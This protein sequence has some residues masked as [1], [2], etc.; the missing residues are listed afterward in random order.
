MCITVYQKNNSY[1]H[2]EQYYLNTLSNVFYL[3]TGSRTRGWNAG[4]VSYLCECCRIITCSCCMKL[5]SVSHDFHYSNQHTL[6]LSAIFCSSL[7]F[8]LIHL[9]KKNPFI[10]QVLN[11][12]LQCKHIV[13]SLLKLAYN[14]Q[15]VHVSVD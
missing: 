4:P 11:L 7:S 2:R 12:N 14:P 6:R 10:S 1:A 8:S 3:L 9:S 13:G 5:C 15:S